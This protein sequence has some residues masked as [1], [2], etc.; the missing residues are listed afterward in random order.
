MKLDV[1][2]FLDDRRIYYRTSGP[3]CAKGGVV[4][5]CPFCGESDP[6]EHMGWDLRT[7]YWNC[8][9]SK[10]H[11]GKKPHRLIMALTGCSYE[12]ADEIVE[13][14]VDLDGF[15]DEVA[16]F[17][18][19]MRP[20]ITPIAEQELELPNSFRLLKDRGLGRHYVNYLIERRGFR[21]KDIRDLVEQYNLH[22]CTSGYWGG[23]LIFPITMEGKLMSWTGRAIS[24]R[25]EL[26]YLSLSN[27]LNGSGQ[28]ALA[29]VKDMIWN[30]DQLMCG[31]ELLIIVEGPLDALKVDFYGQ[32]YGARA[33][34]LFGTGL[35]EEQYAILS[36][37]REK[38]DS[39]FVL[40][41]AG[42]M[43]NVADLISELGSLDAED[44]PLPFGIEDPG[45][46]TPQQVRKCVQQV[47]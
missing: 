15:E 4:I 42:A 17:E 7:G 25:E 3:N 21:R 2:R 12:E 18:R 35:S 27:K 26:R 20:P 13:G 44:L 10:Q 33:T 43:N 19:L 23:R 37:A 34:C 29:S 31:G 40:G 30:Y 39:M 32:E 9:R 6:S 41:D 5:K 36:E 22:Y 38:F 1:I 46:M 24:W 11:G 8:W 14:A 16:K 28:K 45:E 47:Y